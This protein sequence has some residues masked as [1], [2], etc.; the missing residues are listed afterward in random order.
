MVVEDTLLFISIVVLM[1]SVV[2]LNILESETQITTIEKESKKWNQKK[3]QQ[4]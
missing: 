3:N 1:A 4:S 2:I